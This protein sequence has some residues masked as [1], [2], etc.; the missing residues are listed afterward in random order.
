M[1][2]QS[3]ALTLLLATGCHSGIDADE[4]TTIFLANFQV[5]GAVQSDAVA[6]ADAQGKDI[7]VE[8]SDDGSTVDLSG[9][10]T[11]TGVFFEGT[12]VLDGTAHVTDGQ[13]SADLATTFQDVYVP[14]EDVGLD[15]DVDMTLDL[16]STGGTDDWSA[17]EIHTEY[18]LQGT[19]DA[20]GAAEGTADFDYDV[21]VDVSGTEVT[22]DA[23]GEINGHEVDG[24]TG[25]IT[26]NTADYGY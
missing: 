22:V 12:V 21:V 23:S 14:S 19:L 15:G 4:A 26:F 1:K 6:A 20:T 25:S 18:Q 17:T 16:E 10:V 13:V 11:G 9:E 24:M 2:P 8:T 7:T 5:A 3:L